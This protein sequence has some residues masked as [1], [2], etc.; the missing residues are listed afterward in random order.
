MAALV[1]ASVQGLSCLCALPYYYYY[2]F[3]SQGHTKEK[4]EHDTLTNTHVNKKKISKKKKSSIRNWP[5]IDEW[6]GRP[7]TKMLEHNPHS[8][9]E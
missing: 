7:K 9:C 1:M 6:H 5:V 3:L 2:F 8:S 4:E